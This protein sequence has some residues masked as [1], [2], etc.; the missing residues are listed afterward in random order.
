MNRL[1]FISIILFTTHSVLAQSTLQKETSYTRPLPFS[2]FAETYQYD[3]QRLYEIL[4]KNN[5]TKNIPGTV[6]LV[7]AELKNILAGTKS[8]SPSFGKSMAAYNITPIG[9]NKIE[10]RH[11][12][13]DYYFWYIYGK[14]EFLLTDYRTSYKTIQNYVIILH[15][16][17]GNPRAN[18]DYFTIGDVILTNSTNTLNAISREATALLTKANK[19]AYEKVNAKT[20]WT[21]NE[22]TEMGNFDSYRNG[23][24]TLIRDNA[25]ITH[26]VVRFSY[27]EQILIRGYIDHQGISV[28]RNHKQRHSSPQMPKPKTTISTNKPFA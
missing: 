26:D 15:F 17:Q 24:V 10:V 25:R 22:K 13:T 12:N 2:P 4:P 8:W 6:A 5:D 21:V 18:I 20:E 14:V 16:N 7:N 11:L 27:D 23:R 1:I 9:T 3:V 19:E 28:N